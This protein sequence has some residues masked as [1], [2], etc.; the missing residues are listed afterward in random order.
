MQGGMQLQQISSYIE[1]FV[2]KG[3]FETFSLIILTAVLFREP[4]QCC[5]EIFFSKLKHI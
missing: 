2:V 4:E 1:W 3:N 5:S